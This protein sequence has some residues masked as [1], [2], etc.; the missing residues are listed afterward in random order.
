M[1]IE[2][3]FRLRPPSL[4]LTC[5]ALVL[6]LLLHIGNADAAM[7]SSANIPLDSPIYLYLEKLSGFG[8]IKSDIKGIRPFSKAEAARLLLEAEEQ[9]ANPERR[10]PAICQ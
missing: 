8:L 7:L 9:L 2:T 10:L 4:L 6:S 3:A 1:K 5:L